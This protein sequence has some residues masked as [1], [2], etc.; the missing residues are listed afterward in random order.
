MKGD[1]TEKE[2][3]MDNVARDL[4]R[5]FMAGLGPDHIQ[6]LDL[7][8]KEFTA[9]DGLLDEELKS[10]NRFHLR[11]ESAGMSE[12][13]NK[14]HL[15][16]KLSYLGVDGSVN[17][18]FFNEI[19]QIKSLKRLS[20][21]RSRISSIKDISNLSNLT[22]FNLAGAP[23]VEGFEALRA[24][25]HLSVLSLSGNFREM[26]SL[27]HVG[28]LSGVESLTLDGTETRTK[29][30][31]T[32]LPIASM[33]NLKVIML[34]NVKSKDLGLSPLAD[35]QSLEYIHIPPIYLR[36]WKKKDYQLLYESL[37]NLR[38]E[39]VKLAAFDTNFQREYKIT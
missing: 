29:E 6:W 15:F 18:V 16:E 26:N 25:D 24:L 19:C 30:Y 34:Y 21:L 10:V 5:L 3:S 17:Q 28:E 22:H 31:D 7:D 4:D 38:T 39:W 32:L 9:N 27:D 35:I 11:Q 8:D 12:W 33:T 23:G 1:N 2:V 20:I 36:F 13:R 37:P 14:L